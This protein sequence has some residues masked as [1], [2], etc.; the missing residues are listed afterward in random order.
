MAIE[1]YPVSWN[2]TIGAAFDRAQQRAPDV[3]RWPASGMFTNRADAVRAALREAGAEGLTATAV[4]ARCGI[5]NPT[6]NSILWNLCAAGEV[7]R[8]HKT[9]RGRAARQTPQ[10]FIWA[11][12]GGDVRT[13]G[14]D[15]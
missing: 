8:P 12:E 6:A 11:A 13:E 1:V 10:V 2:G 3:R 7:R 15:D 14:L 9:A 5:S 4:M